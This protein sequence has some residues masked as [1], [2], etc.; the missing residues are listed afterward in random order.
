MLLFRL[1]AVPSYTLALRKR[2]HLISNHP[3]LDGNKRIGLYVLLVFVEINGVM[4]T[5]TQQELIKLGLGVARG[6]WKDG[7]ILAFIYSHENE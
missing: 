3:F 1:S 6:K 5:F 7:D 4:L 2:P